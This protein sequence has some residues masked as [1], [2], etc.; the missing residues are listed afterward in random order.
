LHG[1]AALCLGGTTFSRPDELIQHAVTTAFMAASG[2][3]G[4]RWK[5]GIPFMAY[6]VMTIRGAASDSRRSVLRR[7]EVSNGE[8]PDLTDSLQF[9]APPPEQIL[10]EEEEL[11]C[12]EW[13]SAAV[14]NVWNRF[15]EDEHVCWIIRGII[16]EVPAK[17]IQEL[18]GMTATQY[19]TALRRWNRGLAALFPGRRK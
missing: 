5:K 16:N 4:R 3:E 19:N 2:G 8:G 11:R 12:A 15:K 14:R 10:A 9:A 17:R 6:L 1:Y 7:R 13:D 18:S